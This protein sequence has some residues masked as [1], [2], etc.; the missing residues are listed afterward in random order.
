MVNDK[1]PGPSALQ[2][3]IS[4]KTESSEA[5][6]AFIKR[7]KHTV[8]VDRHSGRLRGRVPELCLLGSLNHLYRHVFQF[9]FSNHFDLPSS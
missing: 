6:K 9:S 3:R 7:K 2:K 4:T 8:R 1:D 5:N